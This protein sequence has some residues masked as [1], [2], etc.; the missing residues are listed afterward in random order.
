MVD[1]VSISAE[2]QHIETPINAN[3]TN[4]NNQSKFCCQDYFFLRGVAV[5]GRFEHSSPVCL[6]SEFLKL[7]GII[8][9]WPAG[10]KK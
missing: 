2:T 8:F 7:P 3:Y 6:W 9:L 1:C 4:P 5:S 10:P